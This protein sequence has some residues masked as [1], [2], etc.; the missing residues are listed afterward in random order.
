MAEIRRLIGHLLHPVHLTVH[1]Y[2]HW[3]HW[4]RLSQTRA[5]NS[6]YKQCGHTP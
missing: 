4:R 1:H 3:S 6:H 5:R 2:L